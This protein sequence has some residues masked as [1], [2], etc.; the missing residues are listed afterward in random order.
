MPFVPAQ[1][2]TA[3]VIGRNEGPRLARCLE[4]LAGRVA[5]VI[6]VDSGSSD[7]S[8]AMAEGFGAGVVCLDLDVPF[9][10]ARARNAGLRRVA[11]P[12]AL[13]CDGD[14]ELVDGFLPD[15]AAKLEEDDSLAVVCGQRTE[16]FPKATL[17]N[18][19][20]AME[21]ARPA[22]PTDA[23]G[24]DALLRVAAVEQVGRYA[25]D[26]IAGEEPELCRRLAI[27]GYGIWRLDRTMTVHDAAMTSWRQW[28]RRNVRAGHAYA[29]AMTRHR[30]FRS[31][32]VRSIVLWAGLL[33]LASVIASVRFGPLAIV[34]FALLALAQ[35]GRTVDR[36]R[37]THPGDSAI[38]VLL[39]GL[40]CMLGKWPQ[41]QGVAQF[42]RN[43]LTGRRTGLIEYK[44]PEETTPAGRP[45]IA[46]LTTEY[47]KP[48]HTF[49]RREL[50][51]LERRGW[52]IERFSVRPFAGSLADPADR[53][54]AEKT[55][56]L[57]SSTV[58]VLATTVATAV[59][60]PARFF[61]ALTTTL[62][63]WRQSQRS[64]V[65]HLAYL[66]EA[67]V[68]VAECRRRRVEHV[69]VHFGKN[70]ADVSLLADAL[71]GPSFSMTVH[72]PGEFDASAPFA[73]GEKVAA[74]RFTAAISSFGT[75]QLRRWVPA[76][77]WQKLSI[78]RCTIGDDFL[79]QWS[80]VTQ[81]DGRFVCVGRLTAQKGQLLLID[82]VA[83]AVRDGHDISLTL[84]GD[85]EMRPAI[86]A[87][88]AAY[89]LRDRV[90]ITGWIGEAEVRRLI[91][92][93][94]ALVLPSFAEGLPV[95]IMEALALG[96]P[97]I[98]TMVAG[99]PELVRG[100]GPDRNGW[101][102]PAGNVEAVAAALAD[103]A[104]R[105]TA[106]LTQMGQA[107]HTAVARR[108]NTAVEAVT[109]DRL[110][111]TAVGLPMPCEPAHA[112]DRERRRDGELVPV[113]QRLGDTGGV[114]AA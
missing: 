94:R 41:L 84:A 42:W 27:A 95:A 32:E 23:C 46:Y 38:D 26:L 34:A 113:G 63:L 2:I 76:D 4:S 85:G 14:C 58:G 55:T 89:G 106:E 62:T 111:H 13:V 107:G 99:I 104:T 16:R 67:C 29:E 19:L 102:F 31:R 37:Q 35:I 61:H 30:G 36:R 48:S 114:P 88:V 59:T 7:N 93:S 83:R 74:S 15:A 90:S 20:T 65:R 50:L 10:A 8:V 5:A 52:A 86:E 71:G 40:F 12:L 75:A 33:P 103:A 28:W 25:D 3:V 39:F 98:S 80:P 81:P 69:H 60:R 1:S 43:R 56:V 92:E 51:A 70:S 96:R 47:P 72:G 17:W 49:V 77:H 73:L 6:Y 54:E 100:D 108:H 64:V 57:L 91:T 110:L 11:T 105:S 53:R 9:T 66:A 24:G 45:R 21:W 112:G 109:L 97:V 44:A 68:L 82:A 22:G 101:L 79:S 78:V 87:A 18:R